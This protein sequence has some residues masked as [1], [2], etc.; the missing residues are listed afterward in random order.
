MTARRV[1]AVV[2]L[3][4]TSACGSDKSAARDT[5]VAPNVAPAGTFRDGLLYAAIKAKLAGADIDTA[6]R[7]S[8]SVHSGTVILSGGARDSKALSRDV[9][10]V[11][12]MR[13]VMSVNALT[14]E[15][16]SGPSFASRNAG[17]RNAVT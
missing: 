3:A 10:I 6:A 14:R 13:G 12:A 5:T 11:R 8:V 7:I 1:V 4:M 16:R 2:L 15:S 9:V 17:V